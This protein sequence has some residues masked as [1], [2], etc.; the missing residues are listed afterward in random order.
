MS[1]TKGNYGYPQ[2]LEGTRY[3]DNL[4]LDGDT[5]AYADVLKDP[6]EIECSNEVFGDPL[7]GIEKHCSCTT[8]ERTTGGF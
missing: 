5:D 8:Y 7:V 4:W 2:D 3:K 1:C 6:E